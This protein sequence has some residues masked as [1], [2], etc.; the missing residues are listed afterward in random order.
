[1]IK[2]AGAGDLATVRH[3]FRAYADSLPFSLEYQGFAT[4]LAGLPAPYVPPRGCLLLALAEGE[5]VG[6]AGLRPL[7]PAI[8]E[9]KRLYVAPKHATAVTRVS[10][11]T[12]TAR[13]WPPRS[14]RKDV[15]FGGTLIGT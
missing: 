5:A 2:S 12:P 3:L 4:E 1:V 11:S 13:A 7:A 8:A 10:G 15:Y 6:V 9:I 14:F